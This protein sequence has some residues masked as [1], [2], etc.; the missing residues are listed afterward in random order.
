MCNCAQRRTDIVAGAR[1]VMRGD[2][3]EAK[4][5]AAEVAR[6]LRVD[7]EIARQSASVRVFGLIRR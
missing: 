7:A 5:R 4:R 3:D 6:S 2:L 1:A